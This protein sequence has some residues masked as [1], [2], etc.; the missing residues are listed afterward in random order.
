MA[1]SMIALNILKMQVT[2]NLSIAFNLLE[3]AAGALALMKKRLKAM[4]LITENLLDI[5][6]DIN[7]DK[8]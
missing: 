1:Y 6:E 4:L 2:I 8:E 3:A 5:I 7:D